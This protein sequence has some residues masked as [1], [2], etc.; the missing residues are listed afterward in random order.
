MSL[1]ALSQHTFAKV[2]P[3]PAGNL[4]KRLAEN[5]ADAGPLRIIYLRSLRF[6]GS[7]QNSREYFILYVLIKHL[8]TLAD[9][10]MFVKSAGIP[11]GK[12]L[13]F[14]MVVVQ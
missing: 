14:L 8:Q 13:N 12:L 11:L 4:S 7:L 10:C 6:A 2:L 9:L 5:S 3:K 1:G